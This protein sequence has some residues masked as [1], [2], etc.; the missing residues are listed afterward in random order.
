MTATMRL[1]AAVCSILICMTPQTYG[2]AAGGTL[3]MPPTNLSAI[4]GPM[5]QFP[6]KPP[7]KD[8]HS[9]EYP[10]LPTQPQVESPTRK[11]QLK[12]KD[13]EDE[14]VDPQPAAMK[15]FPS[16]PRS[17]VTPQGTKQITITTDNALPEEDADQD[18][19][20]VHSLSYP[21]QFYQKMEPSAPSIDFLMMES[22]VDQDSSEP[23]DTPTASAVNQYPTE[24]PELV[25]LT[26]EEKLKAKLA[27]PLTREMI[28]PPLKYN[29]DRPTL[30]NFVSHII[31]ANR[32]PSSSNDGQTSSQILLSSPSVMEPSR[33]EE[34]SEPSL[35]PLS[36][37]WNAKA[38]ATIN[39]I[40]ANSSTPKENLTEDFTPSPIP[41]L[42]GSPTESKPNEP[43][44]TVEP[45]D[46]RLAH[47]KPFDQVYTPGSSDG[48][49]LPKLG[50]HILKE[51][52]QN[53][54]PKV[55]DSSEHTLVQFAPFGNSVM[56]SSRPGKDSGAF[57]Y[58][59][60]SNHPT[61]YRSSID[62][63]PTPSPAP[64]NDSTEQNTAPL[65]PTPSNP[66]T[67]SSP[68]P[69]LMVESARPGKDSGASP[70]PLPY[71]YPTGSPSPINQLLKASPINQ[72]PKTSPIN[73]FP[74]T[75]TS[76]MVLS[77]SPVNPATG[78]TQPTINVPYNHPF[79]QGL[80]IYLQKKRNP[81]TA[82]SM[83]PAPS[84][85]PAE[86]S[87]Q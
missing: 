6:N 58:P 22:P 24:S 23:I 15:P 78:L 14:S 49:F 64:P 54:Q 38:S 35:Q 82:S 42:V 26:E 63:S 86:T 84:E 41:S 46:P 44:D 61:G 40:P 75:S 18:E 53:S 72:L 47:I 65:S 51:S 27:T 4:N 25:E 81:S 68:P 79:R 59:I 9:I 16:T 80:K 20:R 73:Q 11:D 69:T 7:T 76:L 77:S 32:L 37:N 70:C 57:P 45:T 55:Q 31:E 74:T 56:G 60:P 66:S 5:S 12:S 87:Q 48:P 50:S 29:G 19:A 3:P 13:N 39:Q 30:K 28:L 17:S 21:N 2:K 67:K 71:N 34:S 36:T 10:S 1:E 83:D 8:Q 62:Q 43:N 85:A 52:R 33:P